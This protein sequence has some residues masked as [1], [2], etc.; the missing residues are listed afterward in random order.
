MIFVAVALAVG[1]QTSYKVLP[2]GYTNA[3]GDG[4][5]IRTINLVLTGTIPADYKNA[6]N[7]YSFDYSVG[8]SQRPA[9]LLPPVISATVGY[10]STSSGFVNLYPANG[11]ITSITN[12]P[13]GGQYLVFG[14]STNDGAV[15]GDRGFYDGSTSGRKHTLTATND[16]GTDTIT[17]T[18]QTNTN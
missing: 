2:Y 7:T 4:F 12:F 1:Q 10:Q 15:T 11:S 5:E 14:E 9:S 13:T 16:A 8:A 3:D 6:G 17:F 18:V